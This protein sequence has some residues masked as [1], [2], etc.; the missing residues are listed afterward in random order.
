MSN[1]FLKPAKD[2]EGRVL[3]VRDPVTMKPLDAAGEWKAVAPFWTRRE[4]DKE[5]IDAT[6]EAP[7]AFVTVADQAPAAPS[8][9][10]ET[11]SLLDPAR[12]VG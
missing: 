3:L 7:A 11:V 9:A 10:R 8:P 5:V 1:R 12:P 2:A 6:A 4:R